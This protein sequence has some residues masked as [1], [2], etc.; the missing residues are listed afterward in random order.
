MSSALLLGEIIAVTPWLGLLAK[1]DWRERILPNYL[2]LGGAAVFLIW[3]CGWGGLPVL[4]NGLAGGV[5]AALLLLIPFLL[6]A[7]GA[8][9]VKFLFA[10]GIL[11][12]TPAVFPMLFFISICG[13]LLGLIMQITGRVD[14]ARVKH[15]LRS[16]FD[17]RYNRGEGRKNL[18]PKE[19]E[20]VRIPFGVAIAAGCWLT[21]LLQLIARSCA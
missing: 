1:H 12:G 14:P 8:G 21:L 5:I 20:R 16:L 18:P 7:A 9:D 2:T 11:A 4:L 10:A 15:F 13:L 19:S 3:R 6:R 17:F